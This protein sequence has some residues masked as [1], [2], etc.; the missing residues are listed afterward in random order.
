MP[1]RTALIV[2]AGI[3]GL[4]AGI[5]LR[6]AGWRVRVFE[7]AANPRELGFA[8]NLAPNAIAALRE[9]GVADRILDAGDL[10]GDAEIRTTGGRVL[11]HINI[12][13]VLG[14]SQSVVTL[15][16]VLHGALMGAVGTEALC[17]SHEVV[18]FQELA[19]AVEIAFANGGTERGDVLIGADGVG[20]VVR[21]HLHADE[22]R[23]RPSRYVAARG[24]A[25]GAGERMRGLS[26]VVYFG[27]GFEAATVRAGKDAI[28]WY[29]SLLAADVDLQHETPR[30][31][32]ARRADTLD[33]HYRAILAATP[34]ADFRI[35]P[36]YERAPIEHWGRGRVTLLGDAAHPMLPHTG[37]GAAQSLEDAVALGL[38]LARDVDCAA[39]L[40]RYERVRAARTRDFVKRGPRLAGLTTTHSAAVSW[41]RSSVVRKLPMSMML[42]AFLVE[43]GPDPHRELR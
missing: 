27:D 3:G 29:M 8:L 33:E 34:D 37:Q 28:Y 24:V 18:A 5:A 14:R 25:S 19:D 15:R 11:R 17:L 13:A 9:L 21:R 22:P 23:P 41:V 12:S 31:I 26:A 10:T 43:G 7:R 32:L 36:L 16:P 4:A 1:A 20:S 6:R 35:E 40:R 30:P 42:K 39:A 38:V 2:G